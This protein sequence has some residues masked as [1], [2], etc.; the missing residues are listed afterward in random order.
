MDGGLIAFCPQLYQVNEKVIIKC[1]GQ[2]NPVLLLNRFPPLIETGTAT[3]AVQCLISNSATW[4]LQRSRVIKLL[5]VLWIIWVYNNNQKTFCITIQLFPHRNTCNTKYF[6]HKWLTKRATE[7]FYCT[8]AG[9][10]TKNETLSEKQL[11]F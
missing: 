9:N 11:I 6:A 1:K 3:V 7:L 2:R 4:L 8:R 5:N 10:K